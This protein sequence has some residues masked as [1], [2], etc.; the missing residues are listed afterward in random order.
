MTRIEIIHDKLVLKLLDEMR[1]T[2]G[3]TGFT[4]MQIYKGYGPQDG[5]YEDSIVSDSQF[6]TLIFTKDDA[7]ALMTKLQSRS[8][9]KKFIYFLT[10]VEGNI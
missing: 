6:Y 1:K 3:L 7:K 9:G 8:R 5:G 2:D 10:E 4:T